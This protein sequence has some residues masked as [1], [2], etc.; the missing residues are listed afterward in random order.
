[1][2]VNLGSESEKK[3]KNGGYRGS[4]MMDGRVFIGNEKKKDEG[5]E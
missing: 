3:S 1:M 4:T 5:R 2:G